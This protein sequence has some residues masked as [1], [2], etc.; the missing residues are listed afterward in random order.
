MPVLSAI[1]HLRHF[2]YDH[3]WKKSFRTE[4]PSICVGNLNFGGT[5]KTPFVE[6]LIRMLQNGS[7]SGAARDSE[8]CDVPGTLF[9]G[10][11]YLAVLS[12]GYKRGTKGFLEV[13]PEGSPFL[14]GDEPLQIKKKFPD[15]VVAVD[16]NRV[17]GCHFLAHPGEAHKFKNRRSSGAPEPSFKRPDII[18]LDDAYQH[19][20]IIPTRSILLTTFDRP[21]C[22]DN[23]APFGHLRDLRCRA[24]AA[25]MIVVTKCPPFLD[26]WERGMWARNL[27]LNMYDTRTCE[28]L[29]NDGKRQKLLFSTISYKD[30]I[31]VFPEG[32]ARYMHSKTA[33]VFSGIADDSAF[34][35][36][37]RG[38][39]KIV[40]KESFPDHHCFTDSDASSLHSLARKF[41]MAALITTEKDAQRLREAKLTEELRQR[42]FYAPICFEML[43]LN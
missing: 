30:F 29:N 11:K 14:Y 3:G 8:A 13:F 5:G 42:L 2:L 27:D 40:A 28:G 22:N 10:Q 20:R 7:G 43:T 31:P 39:Y 33:V 41:P 25:D 9:S 36:Y 32:D 18:I 37:L 19:R 12:R 24:E 23:L 17:R 26:E 6:M 35:L 1:L 4:L 16:E 21:Y 38:K 15:I 34:N